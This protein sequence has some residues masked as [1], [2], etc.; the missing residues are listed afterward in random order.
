MQWKHYDVF[1]FLYSGVSGLFAQAQYFTKSLIST[2]VKTRLRNATNNA[3]LLKLQHVQIH[4]VQL[5]PHKIPYHIELNIELAES[6][7]SI[8][9]SAAKLTRPRQQSRPEYWNQPHETF[10]LL[11]EIKEI[12]V[13]R[14]L[15]HN[16]Y[17]CTN[18]I[19]PADYLCWID[20]LDR[21]GWQLNNRC[22]AFSKLPAG[23][24]KFG[25]CLAPLVRWWSC[26]KCFNLPL[27]LTFQL[28]NLSLKN[29][30]QQA[31]FPLK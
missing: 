10:N 25:S 2:D 29:C 12:S 31:S 3:T 5:K 8:W 21:L 1:L 7:Q 9:F 16:I 26:R 14:I 13:K 23:G 17:N 20:A 22:I 27:K 18:L 11:Y 24:K 4:G 30:F 19:K 28:K 6:F 15:P